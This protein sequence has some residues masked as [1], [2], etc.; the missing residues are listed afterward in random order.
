MR[1]RLNIITAP[2]KIDKTVIA[3]VSGLVTPINPDPESPK[4]WAAWVSR[5]SR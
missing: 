4:C 1:G 2:M 5:R 3:E